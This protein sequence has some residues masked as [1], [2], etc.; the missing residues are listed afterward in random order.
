MSDQPR[1]IEGVLL[2]S[3]D[4]QEAAARQVAGLE[5]VDRFDLRPRPTQRIRDTYLDTADG[6]L[7]AHRVAFR[8]RELD[9]RPL[10][11]WPPSG[12]SWRRPGRPRPSGPS[13][14]SCAAAGSSWP[15]RPREPGPGSPWPTWVGSTCAR[16][17]SA[18]PPAPPGTCSS[19]AARPPGR[20][21]S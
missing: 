4:D 14:R 7:G 8:V 3:A 5:A 10:L 2:V 18:T 19:A 21:P 12:W 17:R 20:W 16:P 9:G 11:G 6:D 1:E 13:W 15:T